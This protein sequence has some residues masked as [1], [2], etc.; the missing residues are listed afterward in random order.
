MTILFDF[1]FKSGDI[2]RYAYPN[3]YAP[4]MDLDDKDREDRDKWLLRNRFVGNDE[5]I[6]SLY[7]KLNTEEIIGLVVSCQNCGPLGD[8][9]DLQKT[10]VWETQ[11]LIEEN[12]FFV[13][14]TPEEA[15]QCFSIVLMAPK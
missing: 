13:Y 9:G 14:M 7:D 2:V 10:V 3:K 5:K 8:T 12:E 11:L 4:V 1:P 6:S 15:E